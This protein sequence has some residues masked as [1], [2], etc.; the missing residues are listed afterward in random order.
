MEK[1]FQNSFVTQASSVIDSWDQFLEFWLIESI[2][3][4]CEVGGHILQLDVNGDM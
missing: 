3:M 4:I 2:S 1:T